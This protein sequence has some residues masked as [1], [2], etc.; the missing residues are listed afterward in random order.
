VGIDAVPVEG[1]RVM[2]P[3]RI[4][5]RNAMRKTPTTP[6]RAPGTRPLPLVVEKDESGYYVVE[7]PTL[8][9]CYTQGRTL[10]EALKNIQEVIA[11]VLEEE[12]NREILRDY[13]PREISFHTITV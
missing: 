10:D 6:R 5:I 11:L 1:G 8:P 9:G 3:Y 13:S 4:V 7:C 12:E 2:V